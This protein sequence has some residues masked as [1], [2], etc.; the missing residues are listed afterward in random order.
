MDLITETVVDCAGRVTHRLHLHLD[1]TVEIVD[2]HRNRALV[3][4]INRVCL[5]P[6]MSVAS[7]VMDI[8]V[9]LGAIG[10]K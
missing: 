3:D 10:F 5:T 9:T 2:A 7:H 1:G 6:G 8:A 4:P